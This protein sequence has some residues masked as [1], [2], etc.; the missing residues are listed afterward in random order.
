MEW[1]IRR[2]TENDV[3]DIINIWASRMGDDYPDKHLIKSSINPSNQEKNDIEWEES[4]CF[5]AVDSKNEVCG[6]AI[7]Q[8]LSKSQA[9]NKLN[10]TTPI[11]LSRKVG[12]LAEVCVAKSCEGN[13]IATELAETRL[14]YLFEQAN[15]ETVIAVSWNYG[16][17]TGANRILESV[18]FAHHETVENYWLQESIKENWVC[19]CGYPCTCTG[20]IY[21]Y[22]T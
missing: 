10:N 6:F 1:S 5:T 17:S 4:T 7:A 19:P 8:T 11:K 16:D 9:D 12:F 13:G 20:V 14:N 3:S 18:G 22:Y 21:V 2:A 15:V